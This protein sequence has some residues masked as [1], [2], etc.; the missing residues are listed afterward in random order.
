MESIVPRCGYVPVQSPCIPPQPTRPSSAHIQSQTYKRFLHQGEPTMVPIRRDVQ[1]RVQQSLQD[2]FRDPSTPF[3]IPPGTT[4]P[5][6]PDELP[7]E[8]HT[9]EQSPPIP[10]HARGDSPTNGSNEASQNGHP[11]P[12]S[13]ARAKL[14]SLGYDAGSL[15]EQSIVWGHHDAFRYDRSCS[16]LLVLIIKQTCEQRPLP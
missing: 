12:A 6:S 13:Q 15:W 11:D 16:A 1:P 2:A 14:V 7:S 8:W 10:A 3:H 4:G 9:A 5:A